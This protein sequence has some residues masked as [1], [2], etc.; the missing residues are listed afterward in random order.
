M[1][2]ISITINKKTEDH[3]LSRGTEEHYLKKR[4]IIESTIS[5]ICILYKQNISQYNILDV[6]IDICLQRSIYLSVKFLWFT[7]Y[8]LLLFNLYF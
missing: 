6:G 8:S 1:N 3:P 5:K 7:R 2:K 4:I